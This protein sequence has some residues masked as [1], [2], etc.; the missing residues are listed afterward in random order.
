MLLMQRRTLHAD[1]AIL[2]RGHA[3]VIRGEDQIPASGTFIVVMNHYERA[4]MGVWWPAFLVT[5]AL[6]ATR[7]ELPVVWLITNRFYRFRLRGLRLPDRVVS[8][9]LARVAALATD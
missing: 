6:G 9:F 3:I 8:W 1:A 5:R 2:L 7:H 4:G